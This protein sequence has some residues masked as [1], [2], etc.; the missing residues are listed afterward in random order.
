[1]ITNLA[2]QFFPAIL[3]TPFQIQDAAPDRPVWNL[4][5]DGNFSIF[6]AWDIIRVHRPQ[7]NLNK[8]N[9]K[10][11]VPFKCSFL[12]LRALRKK[13]PT[14]EKLITFGAD[15]H[16]CYCCFSPGMDTID[17]IFV[18]GHFATNVWKFFAS[19]CGIE[20]S[21]LPLPHYIM[22]WWNMTHKNAAR[23]LLLHIVPI[24]VCWNLWKNRCVASM[25][26]S[27]QI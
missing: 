3:A 24:L 16:D 9:W 22:R 7:T 8:Y 2:P 11:G 17:H 26:L 1:M 15:P 6:S 14:N 18:N 13:L 23:R 20:W 10:K 21:K 25:V 12:L 19:S 27:N 4:N 5:S